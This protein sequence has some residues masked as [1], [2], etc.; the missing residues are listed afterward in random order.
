[1]NNKKS[2]MTISWLSCFRI[3]LLVITIVLLALNIFQ[4]TKLNK[5]SQKANDLEKRIVAIESNEQNS[6]SGFD[7]A[8]YYD[9]IDQKADAALNKVIAIVGVLVTVVTIF[10]GLIAFK[11]PSD[12]ERKQS[13]LE[14]QLKDVK[15]ELEGQLKE[16]R[17]I[18][19][20]SKISLTILDSN[21]KSNPLEKIH[22][23]SSFIDDYKGKEEL[24]SDV[25]LE[26]GII[27]DDIKEYEKARE[28]YTKSHRL[29]LDN[30][31][32]YNVMGVLY[33]K[34][35]L[36]EDNS[37]VKRKEFFELS[38]KYYENAIENASENDNLSNTY[39][40]Y[41]CLM[42]DF[43]LY[44]EAFRL[45]NEAKCEDPD[46]YTAFLNEALT[47]ESIKKY[48]EALALYTRCIDKNPDYADART[49]R[50]DLVSK[51]LVIDP[52]NSLLKMYY[53]EDHEY[54]TK[55]SRTLKIIENR[56]SQ[57]IRKTMIDELISKIDSKIAELE[58]EEQDGGTDDNDFFDSFF[59]DDE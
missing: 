25:Y 20:K 57:S 11:A 56:Y 38:K 45:F 50:I 6:D 15:N 19:E 28:D 48:E 41:A 58:K 53:N 16:I 22:S 59:D 35:L 42:G 4:L 32:F 12:L 18:T 33:N 46:N 2:H 27:Y 21:N 26:R 47:Y 10:G 17:N 1:M 23:L 44:D 43:H 36:S 29:G 5:W 7:Y 37:S 3:I 14:E 34:M 31:S 40:N 8:T 51:M 49:C 52:E 55:E 13:K 24:L 39:C 54:L 30:L 9:M